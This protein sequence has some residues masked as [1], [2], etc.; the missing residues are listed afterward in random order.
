MVTQAEK[1]LPRVGVLLVNHNQ[2]KLTE[3]CIH[4][5]FRSEGVEIVIGLVDN[6]SRDSAP[7]WILEESSVFFSKSK[8]N[9]GVIAAN[10]K[11]YEM[12]VEQDVDYVILL[13]NDT[14]IEPD[15]LFL[16]AEKLQ[17]DSQAGLV[18]PA[19]SY[20]S[21]RE[22]LWHAGGV[23]IPWKMDA[24]PLFRK[25]SELPEEPVE[26]DIVSACAEMMRTGLYKKI[27]YQNPDYFIYHE[28][29]EHSIRTKKM[30]FRNYL[31]PRARIIHHVSVTTGGVL[32]PFAVYFAHRNR[33]LFAAR[34]LN[35]FQMLVFVIYYFSITL[36]KTVVYPVRGKANLVYWIW[37]AVLHAVT[38]KPEKRPEALFKKA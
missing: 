29:A 4:S 36:V 33:F 15:T 31:V 20:A 18:T 3:I 5:V 37:L 7:G 17:S 9:S 13:N 25:V 6:N 11:A 12:V 27:G 21:E 2:W 10:N 28:D 24:K 14:E 30:G 35:W 38:N 8:T 26:V 19:I 32:S 16:L 22:L 1:R 34:N 23:F